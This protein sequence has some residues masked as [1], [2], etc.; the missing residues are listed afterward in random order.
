MRKLHFLREFKNGHY[1][2]IHTA[3]IEYTSGKYLISIELHKDFY[4]DNVNA[5]QRNLSD[6]EYHYYIGTPMH[7]LRSMKIR[8][9]ELNR[10]EGVSIM[11]YYGGSVKNYC[12][13]KK[14][15][16]TFERIVLTGK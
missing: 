14:G 4:G 6:S 8:A 2:E 15:Q 3:D 11:K 13:D 7:E 1:D 9:Y 12:S 5:F 10:P 16:K